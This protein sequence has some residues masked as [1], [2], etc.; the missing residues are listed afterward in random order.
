MPPLIRAELGHRKVDLDDVRSRY[1]LTVLEPPVAKSVRFAEAPAR[2]RSI[3][4]HASSS[5]G[6]EAY[7][8]IA[9]T[10]HGDPS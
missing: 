4:G 10:L 8:A 3:L 5:P 9:R 6:A 1:G 7:R 2:G